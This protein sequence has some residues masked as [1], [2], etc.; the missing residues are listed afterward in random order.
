MTG[1]K[2]ENQEFLLHLQISIV[3]PFILPPSVHLLPLQL[4]TPTSLL[5]IPW[6]D[7]IRFIGRKENMD[8][9]PGKK[10]IADSLQQHL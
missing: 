6:K 5:Q 2:N 10:K 9:G 7:L 1:V 4:P 8:F 3:S